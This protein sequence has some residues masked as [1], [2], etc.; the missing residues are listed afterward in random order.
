MVK[1]VVNK[2]LLVRTFAAV[3]LLLL[4]TFGAV[5]AG[6]NGFLKKTIYDAAGG[7][8]PD[9][10]IILIHIDD[11]DIEQLQWPLK[12]NYYAL[13]IDR[14]RSYDVSVIGFEIFL[15]GK[16][17]FQSVYDELLMQK[18]QE[19]E[20]IVLG[21]QGNGIVPGVDSYV[22]DTL[23][24]PQP[25]NL[26]SSIATGHLNYLENGSISI[27]VELFTGEHTEK[28]FS[29]VLAEERGFAGFSGSSLTVNFYNSWKAFQSYTLLEFFAL[30]ESESDLKEIFSGKTVIIGVSSS[31]IS[32]YIST[33][34][35]DRMPGLAL[36]A[37]ALDNIV[38]GRELQTGLYSFSTV[39]FLFGFILLVF[40]SPKGKYAFYGIILPLLVLL[41][42]L[43]LFRYGNFELNFA[44]LF[45]GVIIFGAAEMLNSLLTAGEALSESEKEA[46]MLKGVL[47]AK[48][49]KLVELQEKLDKTGGEHA[50]ILKQ[51]IDS[52]KEEIAAFKQ[53]NIERE[54]ADENTGLPDADNFEGIVYK[55]SSMAKLVALIKKVAPENITVLI[56]GESGSG[57]ELVAQAVHK[58]SSRKEKNFVA[59]NC[60]AMSETLLESELFG[61]KKGAFTG[62][63]ADK[64]GL[65]E[66]ADGG[67]IFLDEIGETSEHFQVRLL[68]VLQN[69]EIQKVG[70]TDTINVDTRVIAATNKDLEKMVGQ[71]RFR[72]DL[73]YRL[74]VIVLEVPP[75]RDRRE[76]IPLLAAHF[77][78]QENQNLQL[79]KGVI[80]QLSE[81][82]WQGNVR[83]LQ[84]VIKR[85]AILASAEERTIIY[86]ADL[87]DE[88]AKVDRS[89]MG[90]LILD[91]L[92]SKE[93]SHNAINETAKELGGLSRTVVS[94]NFRGMFFKI[95]CE[96]GYDLALTARK[97]A[98][99]DDSDTISKV[100]SKIAT[101]LKN[102]QQD[103]KKASVSDFDALKSKL[104]TKYKN[105]PKKYHVY[106]DDI[107]EKSLKNS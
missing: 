18:I 87:P 13:L 28:A 63:V 34:F 42:G 47:S 21:S 55:S 97:L 98:D 50:Q 29:I 93:F 9:S 65:F 12:R 53:S 103:T 6:V 22:A 17:D 11:Y 62:A 26:D 44:P 19:V 59:L 58:L 45:L 54:P 68:R 14:L 60:A 35:D 85:A 20:R 61:H 99:S 51:Q 71:K 38:T 94:E 16:S 40:L 80:K 2:N 67:T 73:Y 7:E 82:D 78:K 48:E 96:N 56:L 75:L 4:L 23:L 43:L 33:P 15:S 31:E 102:I 69:G 106:L 66:A 105:L 57:K 88:L 72:E 5:T 24:Y 25:K 70:A 1:K 52:L 86:L 64:I 41:G 79:S 90:V 74:K 81:Y 49:A 101:Y 84:S 89:D 76:D 46:E 100:D 8:E 39:V 30:A 104:A 77:L 107:L 32:R 27:P 95:Y 37:F 91:S 92:R 10:S 83:E 36:H 3:L